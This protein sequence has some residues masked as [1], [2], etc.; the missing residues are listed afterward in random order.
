MRLEGSYSPIIDNAPKQQKSHL[1]Y[2]L[3]SGIA[4]KAS[5]VSDVET[6]EGNTDEGNCC[7]GVIP[8][9][10]IMSLSGISS[11]SSDDGAGLAGSAEKLMPFGAAPLGI[12]EMTVLCSMSITDTVFS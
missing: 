7:Q 5:P 4:Y 6:G 2:L 10:S 9:I 3:V 8:G 11:C 1:T 12:V